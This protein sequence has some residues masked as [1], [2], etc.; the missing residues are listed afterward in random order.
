MNHTAD[1]AYMEMAYGLAEKARGR[2]SPNPMVGSVIVK[3]GTIVGHGY[4]KEAGTPHAEI[5]ALLRAGPRAKGGTLYVTL[6]P[7]VH[8]GR[9]PP[10]VAALIRSGL[11]KA[12]VSARDPNPVVNGKGLRALRR[13]GMDVTSGLLKKKNDRMNEVYAKYITRNI[14]FVTLKAAVS[15]DGK[16]AT[17]EHDSKW[18]SS[19][20]TREYVHLL[21]AENDAILIGINTLLRDDPFL[22][23]RHPMWASKKIS[24]IILDSRLRFPLGSKILS[25]LRAGRIIVFTGEGV[26]PRKSESLREKGVEVIA[27]G[28]SRNQLDLK[29][30]LDELGRREITSLLVEGGSRI[31]TDFIENKAADKFVLTISP[32][33]VGGRKAPGIFAGEG[34]DRIRRALPVRLVR[35]F[36]L[37]E[38]V[39]LEG[40]F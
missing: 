26:S 35:S 40:Y 7:C 22:S 10:C 38:E 15:L 30:I 5:L 32:K 18:I 34:I 17:R 23:V 28:K 9:T 11:R 20:R 13:S 39:I 6:E 21:R 37:G 31:L 14:P 25:T 3:N 33:L 24:R 19:A 2:S 8:W 12:V 16:I 36:Q 4:H 29:K 27:V 1:D